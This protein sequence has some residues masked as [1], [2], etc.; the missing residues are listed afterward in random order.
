MNGTIRY[1]WML[2]VQ[3]GRLINESISN[4][5]TPLFSKQAEVLCRVESLYLHL[6]ERGDWDREY[7]DSLDQGW[8]AD[9]F[10]GGKDGVKELSI[11]EAIKHI[12]TH[13]YKLPG[14]FKLM[15]E[16]MRDVGVKNYPWP[17]NLEVSEQDESAERRGVGTANPHPVGLPSLAAAT[18]Q[19]AAQD[20]AVIT[21]KGAPKGNP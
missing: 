20:L 5:N 19:V 8:I 21:K 14:T 16:L 7:K 6:T 11:V 18:T 1:F 12:P 2:F 13:I 17:K 3:Q 4:T 9:L 15:M 10:Y